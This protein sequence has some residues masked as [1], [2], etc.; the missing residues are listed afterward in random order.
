MNRKHLIV[1]GIL[2]AA[3]IIASAIVGAPTVLV[4]GSELGS[5]KRDAG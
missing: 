1:N 2:W 4:T 5:T 3:A